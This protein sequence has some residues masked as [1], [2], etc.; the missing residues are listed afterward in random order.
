LP[1][2]SVAESHAARSQVFLSVA[3]STGHRIRTLELRDLGALV[4]LYGHLHSGGDLPA[5]RTKLEAAWR[6]LC[7]D[8]KVSIFAVE[9]E[10]ELLASCVVVVTPNLT[11]GAR[12]YA[13]IENVVT[14]SQHRRQGLG[15]AV[16]R[17]ALDHCWDR[18]CYKVMLLSGSSN[19]SA[20]AFYASLGF[21]RAAKQ[22]FV[23]RPPGS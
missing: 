23:V 19:E 7:A 9:S 4:S 14:H 10:D 21:D 11:R 8:E 18:D 12:P 6:E 2:G 5:E 22:G 1:L 13:L 20:H 17:A 15:R 16:I 3:Q